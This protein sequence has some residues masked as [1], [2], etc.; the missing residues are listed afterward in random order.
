M[1]PILLAVIVAAI[2][3]VVVVAVLLTRG[4]KK[5][6]PGPVETKQPQQPAAEQLQE[7]SPQALGGEAGPPVATMVLS[8]VARTGASLVIKSGG[9]VGS[10]IQL[11]RGQVTIGSGDDN[12]YPLNHPSV[13]SPHA[14]IKVQEG[15]YQLY[16]LGSASGTT[17][18]GNPVAGAELK[19]G[20]KIT[21][22][23]SELFFTQVSGGSEGGEGA[24]AGSRGVLQARS[25]PAT[26]QSFQVGEQDLVIGRRPGDGGAVIDDTAVSLRHALVRPTPQ[27]CMVYDLGSDN[28]TSVDDASLSGVQLSNGDVVKLG[29]AELQFVLEEKS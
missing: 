7:I 1:D 15:G 27:G 6:A 16:D 17:V 26:G 5:K 14:L 10:I 29:E 18:N 4:G 24:E 11:K 13:S 2:V 21:M 12:D 22:G 25:G 23:G 20:S 9:V 8:T 3:I 28:G 19:N